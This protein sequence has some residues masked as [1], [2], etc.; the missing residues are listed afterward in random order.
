MP[1]KQAC[2]TANSPR[3]QEI[4]SALS[5]YQEERGLYP[6][7]LEEL[8]PEYLPEIPSPACSFI[9]GLPR[10]FQ[11]NDCDSDHLFFY[12]RSVDLLGFY[13]YNFGDGQYSQIWSFLDNPDPGACHG[14]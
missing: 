13:L 10:L 1:I 11:L 5:S 9:S 7:E 12:V 6:Q 2:G 8:V 4:S 14:D 3:I